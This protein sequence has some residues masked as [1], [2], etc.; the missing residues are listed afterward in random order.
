MQAVSPG[1]LREDLLYRLNVFPIHCRRC[2]S[3]PTT[4]R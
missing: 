4:S 2:A 3:A 1:K